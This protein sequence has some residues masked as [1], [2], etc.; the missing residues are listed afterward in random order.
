M[1]RRIYDGA[2]IAI[3]TMHGKE[4]AF[5]APFARRLGARLVRPDAIDTDAFGTFTGEVARAGTM[6][7][8]ARAKGRRAM[9]LT[10]LTMAVA[11]EGAYGPHPHAPL[12][13]GGIELALFLDD[14]RGVEVKES[15]VVSRTNYDSRFWKP[16][17][18]LDAA[19]RGMRFP[20]HAMTA[21]PESPAAGAA[22]LVF[23]G[24]LSE[25]ALAEAARACAAASETGRALLTPDMRAHLN[26]TRMLAIRQAATKLARRIAAGC[27]ACAAPG[28]GFTDIVRGLRCAECGAPTRSPVAEIHRCAACG[29][30]ERVALVAEHARADAGLC[31]LCNP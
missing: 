29:H 30:E 12:I 20:D 16:G 27:P 28:F 21:R 6:L 2:T 11:S 1:P 25:A 19:L 22:P 15:I 23:K 8:A 10:G 17:E 31:D 9:E 5:A 4:R 26:P 14:G 7:E 18:P 13:P 3:G 24:L